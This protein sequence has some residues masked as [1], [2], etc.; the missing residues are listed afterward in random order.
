MLEEE[1]VTTPLADEVLEDDGLEV[2]VLVVGVD[3]GYVD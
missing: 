3:T 2:V 1:D